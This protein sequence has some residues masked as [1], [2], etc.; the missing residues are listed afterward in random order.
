[1]DIATERELQRFLNPEQCAA[2]HIGSDSAWPVAVHRKD[3]IERGDLS[4]QNRWCFGHALIETCR[5]CGA[6]VGFCH[7]TGCG[8]C[9]P[10]NEDVGQLL[11]LIF[12]SN[13]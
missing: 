12:H 2:L 1:M 7:I 6:L 13:K 4:E 11:E 9:I 8:Q 10:V 5:T 3:P